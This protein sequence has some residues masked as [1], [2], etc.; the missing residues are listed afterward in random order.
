ME[1]LVDFQDIEFLFKN[2]LNIKQL[3]ECPAYQD[4]SAEDYLMMAS[5]AL[6]FAKNEL[7]PLNQKGDQTGA[8]LQNGKVILPEGFPEL[9]KAY[10]QNGF[11]AVDINPQFGGQGLPVLANTTLME[12]FLGANCSFALLSLLTKGSANL[13]ATFG[14]E[15]LKQ[16]YCQKMFSGE[17]AGTMC[18]TEPNAG[19]AV[20]DLTTKAI[21]QSDGSYAIEG[22]KIFI[23]GGEHNCTENIIHLV[24]ARIE[25]DP[26][27]S[28]GISLFVVPK[29]RISADGS[30][31]EPNDIQIINI[32]HK[33]GINASPTCL[34]NFGE[35]KQCRGFLIG[36]RCQGL[37]Q[38]F[39][40]M[41]EARLNVGLQGVAIGGT[42][43]LHALGYAKERVQGN[44]TLI[45]E[46]PDVR[47]NL[48]LCK[49]YHEGIRALHYEASLFEDL[50]HHHPDAKVKEHAKDMIDFLTPICKSYGSDRGFDICN[51]AMM[52]YGGY[53]Y[54]AEYPAEQYLR[55]VKI[56]AIYEGTNGVQALD[57]LGR[58]LR[59]KDGGLF[60]SFCAWILEFCQSSE[61]SDAIGK[62]I[63]SLKKS[64]DLLIES[65]KRFSQNAGKGDLLYSQLH[66]S[67]FLNSCGDVVCA[68]LL[69]KSA[70]IAE[71]LLNEGGL[72]SS[73]DTYCKNKIH[74]AQFF[75]A[76][77]LP[78]IQAR[79]ISQESEDRSALAMIF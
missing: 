56:S 65:V 25:G 76:Q 67:P 41:N 66:A 28:K 71:N 34:L 54:C 14:T 26:A 44:K 17:W 39:Q 45:L 57:L 30:F 70:K 79:L 62:C 48:S 75:T 15:E 33:M 5:E 74:T 61:N 13:I 38:M 60:K 4:Y 53:G 64:V 59:I 52:V 49:A 3:K 18:L 10:G 21:P 23:T 2:V 77:I 1:Y 35:N 72:N 22:T 11:F 31:A 68:F 32:E 27:G 51:T 7:A 40:L 78:Q 36:E 6:K 63:P 12:F 69:L 8:Q 50:A 24:L 47:R 42:A 73:L 58:K 43:Y 9:F 29:I 16:L 55:D 20:G 46:Y 19:T 37:P